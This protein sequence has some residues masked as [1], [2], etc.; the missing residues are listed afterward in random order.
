MLTQQTGTL[1]FIYAAPFS[2]F[3]HSPEAS[4]SPLT[5]PVLSKRAS[6]LPPSAGPSTYPL[7]TQL[8]LHGPSYFIAIVLIEEFIRAFLKLFGCS[9]RQQMIETKRFLLRA[10]V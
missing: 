5:T 8:R 4:L 1:Q 2:P 6:L 10:A 3:K 9:L 7:P